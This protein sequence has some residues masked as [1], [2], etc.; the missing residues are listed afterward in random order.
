MDTQTHRLD[1]LP[2]QL[3]AGEQ[4]ELVVSRNV[5]QGADQSQIDGWVAALGE[6]LAPQGRLELLMSRP[7]GGPG[8]LLPQSAAE[9]HELESQWLQRN[10][11]VEQLQHQL[12]GAGWISS[13]EIWEET[14]QLPIDETL[15]RRWFTAESTYQRWITQAGANGALEAL[16]D[17]YRQ[18]LGS[19]LP[20][21][22][23]H[24]RLS[25]WRQA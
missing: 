10:L 25:A 8:S 7:R 4:F 21:T 13:V 14:L 24:H 6:L 11:P 20:Q 9:L 1:Q 19:R 16:K 3:S 15:M 22:I 23:T 2:A 17:R 12:D 5:L 18:R